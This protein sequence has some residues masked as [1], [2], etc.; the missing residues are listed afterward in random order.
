MKIT[1]VGAVLVV[2]AAIVVVLVIRTLNSNQN[3]DPQQS[4]A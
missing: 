4:K 1:V 2:A 3:G